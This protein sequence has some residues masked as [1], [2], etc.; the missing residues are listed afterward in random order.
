MKHQHTP[1]PW[2]HSDFVLSDH[3]DDCVDITADGGKTIAQV[4]GI[5]NREERNANVRLMVNSPGL[6]DACKSAVE[7]MGHHGPCENNDCSKCSR[8]WKKL[9]DIIAKATRPE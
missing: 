7:A 8:T 2:S 5:G 9:H 6:L 4:H 3:C 1:K